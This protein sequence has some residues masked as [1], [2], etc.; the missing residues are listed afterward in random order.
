[1][2]NPLDPV[3]NP[4]P[5]NLLKSVKWSLATLLLIIGLCSEVSVWGKI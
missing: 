1:M 2:L 3:G 5:P 4:P